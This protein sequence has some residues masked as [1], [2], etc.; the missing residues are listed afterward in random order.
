LSND[1]EYQPG[2][3]PGKTIHRR[4]VALAEAPEKH[5]MVAFGTN[6][7][8]GNMSPDGLI[9]AASG[10]LASALGAEILLSSLYRTPCFP[11]GA[12]PDYVNAAAIVTLRHS[13]SAADVLEILHKIEARFGRRRGKRWAARTLDIDLLALDDEVWPDRATQDHWRGL[14]VEAQSRQAPESLILP[15]PRLQDRAFVLVPLAEVAPDWQH[16][17]LH[18]SVAEMLSAL[19][20]VDRAEVVRLNPAASF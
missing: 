1:A 9:L 14:T 4:S 10:Q 12:G 18:R 19:P 6:Q 16:P 8:F 20:E 7:A 13:Q 3:G 17:I 5:A 2:A 11:A 15:H